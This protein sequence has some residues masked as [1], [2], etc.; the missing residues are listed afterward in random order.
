VELLSKPYTREAL[1]Q[2]IN[3]V[4][5]NGEQRRQR[6]D[7]APGPTPADNRT[8]E[9]A[10]E[11]KLTILLV[12]DDEDIRSSIAELLAYDGHVVVEAATAANAIE[13]LRGTKVDVLVTDINLPDRAGTELAREALE[14]WPHLAVVFATGRAPSVSVAESVVLIKPYEPAELLAALQQAHGL[15]ASRRSV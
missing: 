7:P 3:H 14:T 12:E 9:A 6:P 1:A 10:S 11:I 2:K 8:D 4:L 5:R 15:R 13:S